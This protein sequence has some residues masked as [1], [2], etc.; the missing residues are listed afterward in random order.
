[1]FEALKFSR[2]NSENLLLDN[3]SDPV[4]NFFKE[5]HF[6]DNNCFSTE[7]AKLKISCS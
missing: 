2:Y 4:E 1:M 6:A 7:E 3:N 5:S